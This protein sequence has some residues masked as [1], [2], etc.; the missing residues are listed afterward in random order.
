M[1]KRLIR[2][3]KVKWRCDTSLTKY[4]KSECDEWDG[5]W[6]EGNEWEWLW[7]EEN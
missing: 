6:S 2:L 7:S 5:L 4:G 1:A 3:N